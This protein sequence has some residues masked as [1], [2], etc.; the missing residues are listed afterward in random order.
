ME[1]YNQSYQKS[2]NQPD[3]FWMHA[4]QDIA[5]FKKPSIPYQQQKDGT[6]LWFPDGEI[7]MCYVALD[8][9]II[10]GR[11]EQTALIYDSP[12]TGVKQKLTYNF[13][14]DKVTRFSVGLHKLGLR[15]GDRVIIYM[16]M[17]PEAVIA[18]LSCARMGLIHSVVFGGF[19][20]HELKLRIDDAA[21]RI[22]ITA[23]SGV[24]VD[25]VVPYKP[26]VDAAVGDSIYKP[27]YVVLFNRKLG[28]KFDWN[29]RDMD[30]NELLDNEPNFAPEI[31]K[32]SDPLYI[33]YTSGTTGTPK[34]VVRETGGYATA[35]KYSM[36]YIYN[37]KAGDVFWAA[38][39]IGWVVGHSYIVYGP[40]INGSTGILFEGKPIKTPDA[41]T[42]WRIIA[43]H[44]V[45]VMFT[46]P[47]AIRAIKREDPDGE[48]LKKYDLSRFRTFF[49]AGE[50][51]DVTTLEWLQ[52][53]LNIP[54]IDH[55]WQTESGW[56]MIAIMMGI[57]EL[58]VK[59][60][61]AGLPVCGYSVD[62]LNNECNTLGFGEEGLIAVKLPLPPGFMVG[63][64]NNPER[65]RKGYLERFPGYYFTGDGGY[66]DKDGYIYI[67]GRVDDIINVAGHRLSTAEM[68][69]VVSAHPAVAECAV[70]GIEDELK[71]QIPLAIVVYK[72]LAEGQEKEVYHQIIQDVRHKI[73]PVAALKNVIQVPRLPKTR[74]GKILRNIMRAIIDEKPYTVPGTIED[75]TVLDELKL[76]FKR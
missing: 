37:V 26:M 33:L 71:G 47:T 15:K 12:V 43:E 54:I 1:K 72:S 57:E 27:E 28:A 21:P 4:A 59:A 51:C 3:V 76:I 63:L 24:E 13:L 67:T 74:S 31:M 22:I 8:H 23:S 29:D 5:W 2:I 35:L 11:G 40:L 75:I 30:Y 53:Q 70:I 7:N 58:P 10:E 36:Q 68:E 9:H 62:V 55:W 49:L 6:A 17:I 39:D 61:S 65:F 34:G 46:A 38:S 18:M 73:G 50:R 32:A 52:D 25:N 64:W 44:G 56:P 14:L 60:G 66:K 16:P 19:S 48:L 41:S 45:Q 20:A 42:Y 69:E